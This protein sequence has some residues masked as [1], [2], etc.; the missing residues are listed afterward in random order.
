MAWIHCDYA[1]YHQLA[2]CP[3]EVSIYSSYKSIVCVSE[4]TKTSFVRIYP[5]LK[6]KTYSIYNVLDDN[7]MKTQS[8]M[9]LPNDISFDPEY[10]NIVSIGRLDPVKRMSIIPTIANHLVNKGDKIRWLVIGPKG[11]T[12]KEYA[13]LTDGIV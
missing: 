10:F 3:N 6:D 4:F 5:T 9:A 7:M 13:E 1:S 12:D 2:G 11:G 8:K